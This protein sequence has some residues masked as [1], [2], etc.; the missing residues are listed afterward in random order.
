MIA[1]Q[2]SKSLGFVNGFWLINVRSR[3]FSVF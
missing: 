3:W 2:H 1:C